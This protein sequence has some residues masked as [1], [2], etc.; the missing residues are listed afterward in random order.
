M[1]SSS[2]VALVSVEDL[3]RRA[4]QKTY[5]ELLVLA[6]T[7]VVGLLC[8]GANLPLPLPLLVC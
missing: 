5:G 8:S 3:V 7:Y 1:A 6:D 4:V 2:G